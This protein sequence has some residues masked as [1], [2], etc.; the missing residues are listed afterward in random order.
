MQPDQPDVLNYLGYSWVI[1]GERIQ[2]A[3]GMLQKAFLAQP[4]SGEIADSLGWAYYNL[5]DFRQAVQ[6]LERAVS[7]SP[8]SPEITDHL[9]DAYWR[10]GRKTE[11]QFQWRR[12]LTLSPTA[13][14]KAA[15]EKKLES[16]LTPPPGPVASGAAS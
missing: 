6:R 2:Q 5:G 14:L 12:V 11:A 3:L 10:A 13:E 4:D 1:R 8:V 15:A 9:G 16:G 7:L